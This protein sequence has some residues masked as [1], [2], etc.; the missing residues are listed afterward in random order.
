M[1]A[2][3]TSP[4]KLV[5]RDNV[6]MDI[7]HE[8]SKESSLFSGI[9]EVFE[10]VEAA[11]PI[12]L[13]EVDGTTL[14]KVVEWCEYRV[15]PK[16]DTTKADSSREKKLEDRRIV[17]RDRSHCVY[18]WQQRKNERKELAA[19]EEFIRNGESVPMELSDW[20]KE[21]F[22]LDLSELLD[23][24]RAANYLGIDDLLDVA[25]KAIADSIQGKSTEE[26]RELFGISN[27]WA[28]GEEEELRSKY[29]WALDGWDF[30]EPIVF[31]DKEK[32]GDG[33][34]IPE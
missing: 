12:P 20:D 4:L 30:L 27:D 10:D 11:G 5:S 23:L 24:V 18:D 7:S 25:C 15:L 22:R 29:G 9:L 19:V 16:K 14:R 21:F 6:Q 8:A 26:M 2:E 33:E 1:A 17:D 31:G 13:P 28:P 32:E 34:V 3:T